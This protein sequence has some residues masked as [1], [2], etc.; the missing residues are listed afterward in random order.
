MKQQLREALK[1]IVNRVS[2]LMDTDDMERMTSRVT[3]LSGRVK[4]DDYDAILEVALIAYAANI[5]EN[6]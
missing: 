6:E 2:E 4:E 1:P 3:M 5:K